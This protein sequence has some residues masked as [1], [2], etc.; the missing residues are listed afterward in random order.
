MQRP[1]PTR[2]K[3]W[4]LSGNWATILGE[5]Q[6][7]GNLGLVAQNQGDYATAKAYLEQALALF[8]QLGNRL[9][10][11]NHLSNL[12][13]VVFAQGDYRGAKIYLEQALALYT[14]NWAT[15]WARPAP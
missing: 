5:A 1:R 2:S 7:L 4:R 14:G 11:A 12:G 3:R 6:P 9:G 10:E 8:R 15:A 13:L